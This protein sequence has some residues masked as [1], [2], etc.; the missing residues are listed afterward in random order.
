MLKVYISA[1]IEGVNS[2]VYPHQTELSGGESYMKAREQQQ[3]ELSCIIKTLKSL[4]VEK[5]TLND[6]HG[7]MDNISLE[8]LESGVELIT[9]KPRAVS[10]LHNLD[11]SY[12]CAFFTGYHAMAASPK[13]VLAHTLSHIFSSVRLN[14]ELI[15]EIGLNAVYAGLAGVPVALITG[16]DIACSE[17]K[18]FL[19][20]PNTVSVKKAVSTNCAICRDN[21]ELFKELELKTIEALKNHKSFIPYLV[22]NPPYLLELAF[23][24]R[25][26]ADIAELLPFIKRISADSVSYNSDCYEEIYRVI[27]FLSATLH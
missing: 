15:G 12:S 20:Q 6:A 9:G 3:K 23:K 27:Q 5:I 14:G 18:S 7:L 24:E 2:V 21:E 1:D 19:E 17:A 16:D 10:M 26:H 25:R 8:G 4:G 11:S 13:G 22:K